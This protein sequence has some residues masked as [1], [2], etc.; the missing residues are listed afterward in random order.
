MTTFEI[1][2][3][4]ISV[5]ATLGI[6][7]AL[8]AIGMK[9]GNL[10]SDEKNNKETLE[11]LPCDRHDETIREL[12]YDLIEIKTFIGKKSKKKEF[13]WGRK[14]SPTEL[15]ENGEMLFKEIKGGEFL[16]LNRD[17]LI[18]KLSDKRPKTA[19]DVENSA[20]TV[21]LENSGNDFFNGIK[22]W[23]YNRPA[24]KITY[25]NEPKD[26]IVTL[27]DVCYVFSLPLRNMYLEL[28][29]ELIPKQ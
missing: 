8:Y 6:F 1:I 18:A 10:E 5:L 17:F 19:L 27:D 24:M 22:D 20:Y 15:N 11:R 2:V 16:S 26:Y 3:T 9:I 29:P 12:C 13:V 28:H 14:H 23:I 21:L 7:S 25:D 4:C